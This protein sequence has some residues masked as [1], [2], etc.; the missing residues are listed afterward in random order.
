MP[1]QGTARHKTTPS[2]ITDVPPCLSFSF[3]AFVAINEKLFCLAWR[4]AGVNFGPRRPMKLTKDD[5]NGRTLLIIA[6]LQT[7]LLMNASID[8]DNGIE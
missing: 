5:R 2:V 8:E 7:A 3:S 6:G 4:L 1:K